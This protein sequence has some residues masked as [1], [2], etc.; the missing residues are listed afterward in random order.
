[1]IHL[2]KC[3]FVGVN[4]LGESVK[5]IIIKKLI[6]NKDHK[7][8]VH[9][10]TPKELP[11]EDSSLLAL[12]RATDMNLKLELLCG[13]HGNILNKLPSDSHL[14][15]PIVMVKLGA[16]RP[17]MM[18]VTIPH[19]LATTSKAFN[20]EVK[21]F[22]ISTF[23]IPGVLEPKLYTLDE[24]ACTVTMV[25]NKQQ[26]FVLTVIGKLLLT[27][28]RSFRS[29]NLTYRPPAIKCVYYVL[30]EPGNHEI[31]VKVY[32]AI[33]LPITWK[34]RYYNNTYCIYPRE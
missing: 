16:N 27:Q 14:V 31:S 19:A 9:V 30:S 6:L 23:G 15:G 34:V 17:L 28:P 3:T 29:V 11:P 26:I 7:V 18:K 32:C 24:K 33:D 21:L 2:L 22:A 8:E 10:L 20:S 5:Q 12:N 1:M 13:L 4:V 25:I